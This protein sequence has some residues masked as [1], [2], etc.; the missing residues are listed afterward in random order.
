MKTID[1]TELVR[2]SLNHPWTDAD[3]IRISREMISENELTVLDYDKD[4]GERWVRVLCRNDVIAMISTVSPF[5]FY[6]SQISKKD[7]LFFL[8]QLESMEDIC[9]RI[10][11]GVASKF[12]G[13]EFSLDIE[14]DELSAHDF[15]ALTAT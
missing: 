15:Y 10:D 7:S 13:R 9:I 4:S 8:V 2:E 11:R 1:I 5:G 3:A 6:K 12:S 14:L